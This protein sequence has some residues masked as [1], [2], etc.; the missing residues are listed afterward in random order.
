MNEGSIMNNRRRSTANRRPQTA[1]PGKS[2]NWRRF[3]IEVGIAIGVIN[4]LAGFVF[5]LFILPRMRH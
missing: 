3:L 1:P 5:W 4:I 2:F